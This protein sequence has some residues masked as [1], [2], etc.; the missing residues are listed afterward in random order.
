MLIFILNIK[1]IFHS[2]TAHHVFKKIYNGVLLNI[3]KIS[4][5]A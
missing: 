5:F 2:Y 4:I 1:V 3:I